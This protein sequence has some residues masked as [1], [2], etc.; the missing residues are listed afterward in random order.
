MNHVIT[1]YSIHYT[2]L[3]DPVYKEIIRE[4]AQN[5]YEYGLM[6]TEADLLAAFFGAVEEKAGHLLTKTD[7]TENPA[8]LEARNNFV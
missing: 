1:S 5:W 4:A 7:I 2:K 3:Y 8:R 6:T